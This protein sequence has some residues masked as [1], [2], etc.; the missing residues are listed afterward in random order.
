M[1]GRR[2]ALG[3]DRRRGRRPD[4]GRPGPGTLAGL[5]RALGPVAGTAGAAARPAAPRNGG[6]GHTPSGP[7]PR[8][9]L[10]R[11]PRLHR[12]EP[13]PSR[14]GQRPAPVLPQRNPP[15]CPGRRRLDPP[16]A[17]LLAPPGWPALSL[18]FAPAAAGS[19]GPVPKSGGTARQTPSRRARRLAPGG[20]GRRATH[21]GALGPG[22]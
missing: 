14:A 9:R 1:A 5:G 16:A 12:A 2:P 17:A 8:Q 18:R 21:P 19:D 4:A 20:T 3:L 10:H 7:R 13:G 15:Q 6:P 22:R 11:H